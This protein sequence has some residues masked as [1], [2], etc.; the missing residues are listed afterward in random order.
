MLR[1]Q[2][3]SRRSRA[4]PGVPRKITA[5]TVIHSGVGCVGR[6]PRLGRRQPLRLLF[7]LPEEP[8]LRWSRWWLSGRAPRD[9]IFILHV[10]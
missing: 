5:P 9:L 7:L 1:R 10:S 2:L 6:R 3:P 8:P 4:L